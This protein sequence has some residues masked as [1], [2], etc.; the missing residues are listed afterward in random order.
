[1]KASIKT[2]LFPVDFFQGEGPR[3]PP[4]RLLPSKPLIPLPPLSHPAPTRFDAPKQA[5][6]KTNKLDITR[7]MGR[8]QS[9]KVIIP[10]IPSKRLLRDSSLPQLK[11]HLHFPQHKRS[12]LRLDAHPFPEDLHRVNLQM[13]FGK[14]NMRSSQSYLPI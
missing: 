9:T 2:P 14:G 5:F 6:R 1:M 7:G 8:S 4:L 12:Q 13:T 11:P 3:R 10:E